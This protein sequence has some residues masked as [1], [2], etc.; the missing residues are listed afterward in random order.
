MELEKSLSA[1]KTFLIG[2]LANAI[3]TLITYPVQVVQAK[4]RV[5]G[6]LWFKPKHNFGNYTNNILVLEMFGV[7]FYNNAT[8][9]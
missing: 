2:A 8:F 3:A 4:M 7:S 1:K 9:I 6:L 5:S